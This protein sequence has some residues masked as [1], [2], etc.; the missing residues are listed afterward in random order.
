MLALIAE[1]WPMVVARRGH[2]SLYRLLKSLPGCSRCQCF[3]PEPLAG[4]AISRSG[5]GRGGWRINAFFEHLGSYFFFQVFSGSRTGLS[6]EVAPGRGKESG[7]A[8]F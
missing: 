1:A 2:S 8:S 7:Q 6:M 4:V 5:K 3:S